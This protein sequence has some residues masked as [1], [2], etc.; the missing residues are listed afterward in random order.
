[1][2]GEANAVSDRQRFEE[3]RAALVARHQHPVT[4]RVATLGD[5]VLLAGIVLMS[6]SQVP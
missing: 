1:M 2:F 3:F 5:F 4:E 6:P